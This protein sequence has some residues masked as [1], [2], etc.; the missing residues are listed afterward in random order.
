[1]YLKK[2][3]STACPLSSSADMK[4]ITVLELEMT[5]Q[6]EVVMSMITTPYPSTPSFDSVLNCNNKNYD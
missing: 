6:S 5:L 4:T 2:V 1:M 3:L